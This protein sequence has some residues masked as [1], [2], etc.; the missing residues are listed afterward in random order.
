MESR[1][2]R[3]LVLDGVNI[4]AEQIGSTLHFGP[5]PDFNGY[6]SAHFTRN[7]A[8]G[9]GFNNDFHRYQ[10][11]WTPDR[12]TFKVFFYLKFECIS[13]GVNFELFLRLMML[14]LARFGLKAAFGTDTN[15]VKNSQAS[16][17]HGD[18]AKLWHH[19]IKKYAKDFFQIQ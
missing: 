19:L 3:N 1:G 2:N 15:S 11:E 18:T 6:P 8:A 13:V 5:N 16:Q 17:I 7:S 12:I 9:N 10:M 4:G 14:R